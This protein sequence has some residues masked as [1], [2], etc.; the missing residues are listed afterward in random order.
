MSTQ[1]QKVT[2]TEFQQGVVYKFKDYRAIRKCRAAFEEFARMSKPDDWKEMGIQVI[3]QREERLS[4][5]QPNIEVGGPEDKTVV[6]FDFAILDGRE[7]M[8]GVGFGTLE[9]KDFYF[10]LKKEKKPEKTFIPSLAKVVMTPEQ[11]QE[12]EAALT[13]Y[14]SGKKLWEEWGL[15]KV[16]E[17]GRATSY[18]FWGPPGTGKTLT[19]QAIAADLGK[20]LN[21]LQ[22]AELESSIP[23]EMERL[24]QYHFRNAQ[25]KNQ[26]LLFDECDS[27]IY[28]RGKV[29]MILGAQIN[30]L[31]TSLENFDG[32]CFFTTN[33][34]GNLDP[35]MERRI[36][37]KVE[38]LHPSHEQRKEIWKGLLPAELPLAEGVELEKLAHASLTGGHIKNAV[39]RAARLALHRGKRKVDMECFEDAILVE[40]SS[41]K[42]FHKSV[43][44]TM[45]EPYS[46]LHNGDLVSQ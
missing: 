16:I 34:L 31:L 45:A 25:E 3:D 17:K 33:R 41:F 7:T 21:V 29:G 27:L 28:N 22:T 39:V 46:H 15:G 19:A 14:V 8:R 13:Q 32:L 10:E 11:R 1:V 20:E 18:L 23:G 35:A 12:I 5:L 6:I 26:V 30:A 2:P 42:Q 40:V 4:N 38:F 37:A 44:D 24:I 9:V 36:A 43:R